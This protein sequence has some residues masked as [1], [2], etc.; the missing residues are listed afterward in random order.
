MAERSNGP[1]VKM[2][3]VYENVSQRGT[4]YFVAYMGA[5]KL[6]MLPAK[7][8]KEGEPTWTLFVQE[9]PAKPAG[10]GGGR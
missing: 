8:A 1:M 10:S 4:R 7:D 5:A 2:A 3:S 9:R 6:V